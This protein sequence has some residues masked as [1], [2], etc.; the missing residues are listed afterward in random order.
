MIIEKDIRSAFFLHHVVPRLG[1]PAHQ[2]LL[3]APARQ[4]QQP[5]VAAQAAVADV[6]DESVDCLDLGLQHPAKTEIGLLLIR[7]RMDFENDG[8]HDRSYGTAATQSISMSK[9]PGHAGT[10]TKIRSGG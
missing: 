9:C 1:P 10:L 4:R 5:S 2:R 3:V 7:L 8:E 6:V